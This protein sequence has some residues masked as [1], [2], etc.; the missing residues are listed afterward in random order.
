MATREKSNMDK[1]ITLCD[2]PWIQERWEKEYGDHT[3]SGKYNKYGGVLLQPR[4]V[5]KE[6]KIIWLP[7][8]WNPE[9]GNWQ[10]DDLILEV[11]KTCPIGEV[12]YCFWGWKQ[13]KLGLDKTQNDL[14]LKLTWL[15]ELIKEGA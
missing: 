8:G 9:T 13:N 2:H 7:V 5:R 3:Y 14:I 10:V 12:A 6:D 4:Q 15:R 1:L 11:G